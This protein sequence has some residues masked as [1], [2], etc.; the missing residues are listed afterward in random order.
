MFALCCILSSFLKSSELSLSFRQKPNNTQVKTRKENFLQIL[1]ITA[2]D[3]Y[4]QQG[5][6]DKENLQL[7]LPFIAYSLSEF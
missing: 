5:V 7:Q 3:C 2:T 6:E 4:T 1:H